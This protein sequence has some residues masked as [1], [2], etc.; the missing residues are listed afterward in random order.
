MQKFNPANKL[1]HFVSRVSH[2]IMDEIDLDIVRLLLQKYGTLLKKFLCI[3]SKLA[4]AARGGIRLL[5][6][7]FLI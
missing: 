3:V 5:R 2:N 1:S 4:L 7:T 6:N